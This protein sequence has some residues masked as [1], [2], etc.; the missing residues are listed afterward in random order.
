MDTRRDIFQAIADPTRRAIIHLIS[1]KPE[2]LTSISE[3]FDMSRQAVTLHIKILEECGLIAIK[4]HGRERYCELKPEKLKEVDEWIS[5]YRTF[6]T[7]KFTSLKT[8]ID[9]EN[10]A[11]KKTKKV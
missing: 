2:N 11:E 6:W 9:N 1:S 8:F 10:Q 7:K 3:N 5:Y 4:Q